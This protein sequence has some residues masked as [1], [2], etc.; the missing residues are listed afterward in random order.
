MEAEETP[1]AWLVPQ[2]RRRRSPP[3]K[4][5]VPHSPAAFRKTVVFRCGQGLGWSRPRSK[6]GRGCHGGKRRLRQP[7]ILIGTFGRSGRH[8]PGGRITARIQAAAVMLRAVDIAR[9]NR[10]AQVAQVGRAHRSPLASRASPSTTAAPAPH[11][12]GP[13]KN[14]ASQITRTPLSAPR[15]APATSGAG[16]GHH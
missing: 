7:R 2:L 11:T 4:Y 13:N 12:I 1:P 10:A 16:A 5:P 9:H 6:S 8:G 14:K 3:E 15:G